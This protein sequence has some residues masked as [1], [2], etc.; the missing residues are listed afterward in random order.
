MDAPPAPA[1]PARKNAFGLT[2]VVAEPLE[3]VPVRRRES[4]WGKFIIVFPDSTCREGDC[5]SGNFNS[6]HKGLDGNGPKFM[7]ALY[8]LMAH[9]DETYRTAPPVEVPIEEAP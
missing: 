2:G 9:V 7:D 3:R 6:N 5:S 1:A 8:E 4:D